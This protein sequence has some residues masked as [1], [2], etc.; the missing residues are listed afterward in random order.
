M[1]EDVLGTMR[2]ISTTTYVEC[3]RC[4]KPTPRR[5]AYVIPSDALDSN[6]EYEQLCPEC[7]A[8]LADGEQDLSASEP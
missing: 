2:T 6:S 4:G 3:S 8:A 1:E 5:S 7:Y